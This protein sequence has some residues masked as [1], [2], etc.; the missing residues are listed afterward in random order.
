MIIMYVYKA[1]MY[2]EHTYTIVG[3]GGM[4][5]ENF[6]KLHTDIKYEWFHS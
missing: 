5:Q 2:K 6:E 4:P 1:Q 3:S